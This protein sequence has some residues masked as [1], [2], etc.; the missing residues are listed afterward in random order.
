[1]DRFHPDSGSTTSS[2]SQN[3]HLA[4]RTTQSR[5]V[6]SGT[7]NFKNRGLPIIHAVQPENSTANTGARAT[8]EENAPYR[9]YMVNK[10]AVSI[11]NTRSSR[12]R[13]VFAICDFP[14][15]QRI[16]VE[17][18]V[19]SC[20]APVENNAAIWRTALAER[21]CSIPDMHQLYCKSKFVN[22][23]EMPMG[24]QHLSLHQSRRFFSFV[25]E[26]AFCNPPK[27]LL[28]IYPLAGHIN[29]ACSRCANA[30]VWIDSG[31]PHRITVRLM[32]RV[33][34]GEEIFINYNRPAGNP[35]SCAVCRDRQ[36]IKSH[37][38][39]SWHSMGQWLSKVSSPR[40]Q[41]VQGAAPEPSQAIGVD[42][43]DTTTPK[44]VVTK[45]SQP[46]IEITPRDAGVTPYSDTPRDDESS[47]ISIPF[48]YRFMAR[49][50]LCL[51]RIR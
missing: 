48:R 44:K 25:K 35:F 26:Y 2:D 18:P 14:E 16:I 31:P 27:S 46:H 19:F 30:E 34:R 51:T 5:P 12:G 43:E 50:R 28:H 33:R 6:E 39:A 8:T 41:D 29:H 4:V 17:S 9:P 24:A 45:S 40:H 47:E 49:W 15:G 3:P 42:V 11:R 23:K 36:G 37:L 21:W 7:I 10:L 13:G 22:L 1:M 32:K 38:K 20:A